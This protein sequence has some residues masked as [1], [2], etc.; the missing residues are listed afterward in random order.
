MAKHNE[1]G[2]WG[3]EKAQEYLI[4]KGYMIR[5]CN[6]R[7]GKNELDIV[8]EKDDMLVVVEVK[9][10]S[11]NFFGNPEDFISNAKMKRTINA[12]HHYVCYQ[13][14]NMETR[15]DII[16]ILKTT[17]GHYQI[18]HIEDAFMPSWR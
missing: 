2:K 1:L 14:I 11:S 17:E 16:S 9:M 6:W 7:S 3:E 12:A 18:E 15:F 13:N 5:H 10:R 4:S 8:A